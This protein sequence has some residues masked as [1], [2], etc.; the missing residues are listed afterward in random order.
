MYRLCCLLLCL[1]FSL[2]VGAVETELL[3]PLSFSP[4]ASSLTSSTISI[5][6]VAAAVTWAG[7]DLASRSMLAKERR[8]AM[9]DKVF[10]A[11]GLGRYIPSGHFTTF[12]HD[13][14]W[15]LSLHE[16]EKV[17]LSLR[18]KW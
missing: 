11:L 4:E 6:D 8:G 17:T 7:D 16:D 9:R 18:I 3:P 15:S 13:S 1:A 2:P 14:R 10:A 5:D 12:G